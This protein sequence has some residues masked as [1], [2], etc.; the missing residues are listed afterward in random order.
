MGAALDKLELLRKTLVDTKANFNRRLER[1]ASYITQRYVGFQQENAAKKLG[2]K[3]KNSG[4]K[5]PATQP[6]EE[7]PAAQTTME[8]EVAGEPA[9]VRARDLSHNILDWIKA[10][11]QKTKNKRETRHEVINQ[12]K[13]P[14]EEKDFHAVAMPA[15]PTKESN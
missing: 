7:A 8:T 5:P 9:S 14:D 4:A 13:I 1:I 3:T 15:R 11:I 2:I 6:I 12:G 10:D